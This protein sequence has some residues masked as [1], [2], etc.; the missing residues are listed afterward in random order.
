VS[1]LFDAEVSREDFKGRRVTIVGLGKGRTA[2]GLARFLVSS[3]AHVTITDAKSRDQLA[4]GIG[5]NR[6]TPV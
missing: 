1:L 5:R 2:S 3:G 4:E 6:D